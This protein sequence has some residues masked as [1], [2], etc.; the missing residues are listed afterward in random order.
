[1]IDRLRNEIQD[2]LDQLLSEAEK[3]RQALAA[4]EPR[5]SQPE[6][7]VRKPASGRR[8]SAR[9]RRAR[10]TGTRRRTAPGATKARVLGAMTPEKAM[11]AGEVATATGL[12]RP[13]VS[14]MLSRLA[15]TGEVR[16]V[17]RGYR[18]L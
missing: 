6:P 10:A 11:T 12:P 3:L 9:P 7:A 14:T 1:M 15:K 17:E 8:A 18:L 13:S 5:G 2:R 16:K 4:L